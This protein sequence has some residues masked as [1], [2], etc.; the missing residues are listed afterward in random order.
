MSKYLDKQIDQ[1]QDEEDK[2]YIDISSDKF[3]KAVKADKQYFIDIN[4][5]YGLLLHYNNYDT[6]NKILKLFSLIAA[7]VT[8]N[9]CDFLSLTDIKNSFDQ[10]FKY[11]EL[12]RKYDKLLIKARDI[13]Y[14]D[15]QGFRINEFT[16]ETLDEVEKALENKMFL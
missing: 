6:K 1:S 14:V 4:T 5:E 2:E 11:L 3:V 13:L 7:A 15:Y 10:Y 8:D 9:Q 12:K 16:F